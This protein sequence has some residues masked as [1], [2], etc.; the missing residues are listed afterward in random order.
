MSIFA[1]S[2][3]LLLTDVRGYAFDSEYK[4]SMI[5]KQ[6]SGRFLNQLLSATGRIDSLAKRRKSGFSDLTCFKYQTLSFLLFFN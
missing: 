2:L 5:E 6:N 3:K 4:F 1:Q